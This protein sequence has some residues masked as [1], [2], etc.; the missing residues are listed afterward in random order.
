[1]IGFL[2]DLVVENIVAPQ[3]DEALGEKRV[4]LD[5]DA[6]PLDVEAQEIDVRALTT[7]PTGR[8]EIGGTTEFRHTIL[9]GLDVKHTV[10]AESRRLR[11]LILTD[12]VLRIRD[13][14]FDL[15]GQR[16]ED[17]G[18]EITGLSFSIDYRP[19]GLGDTNE[20]ATLTVT[21]ETFLDS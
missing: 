6:M 16:D 17:T 3:D 20:S 4:H 9:I 2:Y 5:P 10:G 18:Q 14:G 8:F 13:V 11:D 15:I 21:I 1:M 12:L 7:V 19:A